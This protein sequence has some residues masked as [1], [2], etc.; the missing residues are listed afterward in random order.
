MMA[1]RFFV[2]RGTELGSL[3]DSRKGRTVGKMLMAALLAV[4]LAGTVGC[5]KSKG[6]KLQDEGQRTVNELNASHDSLRDTYQI[7]VAFQSNADWN[8]FN[9]AQRTDIQNRLTVII[10]KANRIDEIV[11]NKDSGKIGTNG[12]H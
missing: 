12:V 4:G 1:G 10:A 2:A 9:Q 5:G 11:V 3:R 7:D 6:E 8:R